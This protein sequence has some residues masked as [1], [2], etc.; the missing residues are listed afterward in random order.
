MINNHS[1][2]RPL[3]FL[4]IA[5][6]AGTTV[7][8]ILDNAFAEKD[9]W[10]WYF[11][12]NLR[13]ISDDQADS[14]HFYRGH[15]GLELIEKL[16]LK[17]EV[18]TWLREPVDLMLSAY[19]FRKQ[20]REIP[21]SMKLE[22]WMEI[23]GQNLTFRGF[24]C[25]APNVLGL[26]ETPEMVGKI[27]TTLDSC[28]VVGLVEDQEKSIQLLCYQFGLLPPERN[29]KLN[30]TL[31]RSRREDLTQPQLQLLETASA[32][33][34]KIYDHG[35]AIFLQQCQEMDQKLSPNQASLTVVERHKILIENF[36]G[37]YHEPWQKEIFYTFDQ[38]LLDEFHS[39]GLS[40][41]A[42]RSPPISSSGN[43]RLPG[44]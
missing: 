27:M 14:Y 40:L 6:T 38:P 8:T 12:F 16:H 2:S 7:R 30:P 42:A 29:L 23:Y 18:V 1:D 36:W 32:V 34:K 39:R 4:H 15:T 3:Y 10:P 35:K 26:D 31:R 19:H 5:K 21:Q 37:N 41:V 17:P 24:H 28:R 11:P 22:E 33:D 13:K 9:I 44:H 43:L 25:L 20:F